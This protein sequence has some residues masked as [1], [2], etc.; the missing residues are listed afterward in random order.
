MQKGGRQSTGR[1]ET[2]LRAA[3]KDET[4]DMAAE[5]GVM[6]VE[7]RVQGVVRRL[8]RDHCAVTAHAQPGDGAVRAEEREEG[9]GGAQ[10][11]REGADAQMWGHGRVVHGGDV[12]ATIRDAWAAKPEA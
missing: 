11:R 6:E 2:C 12:I 3:R 5:D 8:K 9:G 10:W 1:E 4:E 7:L